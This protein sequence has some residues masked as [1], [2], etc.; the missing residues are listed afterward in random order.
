M[1]SASQ[2]WA[3]VPPALAWKRPGIPRDWVRVLKDHPEGSRA[4]PY[5][6]WLDTRGPRTH[7]WAHK[8]T[9]GQNT[10]SGDGVSRPPVVLVPQSADASPPQGRVSLWEI[11]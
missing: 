5:Y 4:L 8:P 10:S 7:V 1:T 11:Q 3:R 6:V 9:G 2:R